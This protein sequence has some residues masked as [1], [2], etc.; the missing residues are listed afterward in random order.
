MKKAALF[1]N[2]AWHTK[3]VAHLLIVNREKVGITEHKPRLKVSKLN[4]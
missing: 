1:Q 3:E 4:E 2:S